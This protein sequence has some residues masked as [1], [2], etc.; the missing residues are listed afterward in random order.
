MFA[1]SSLSMYSRRGCTGEEKAQGWPK[2]MKEGRKTCWVGYVWNPYK[3]SF[4]KLAMLAYG[5]LPIA[6]G[7]HKFSYPEL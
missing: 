7:K 2:N 5:L 3:I 6:S 1:G 4:Y